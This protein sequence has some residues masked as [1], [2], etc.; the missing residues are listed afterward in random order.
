[1]GN[2]SLADHNRQAWDE[3]AESAE[4]W[5]Q[6]VDGSTL[7]QARQ[8]NWQVN[9]TATRPVPRAWLEPVAGARILCLAAGGGHQGPILAAAGGKVTVVD[10]SESQLAID[11]RLA[12]Q[13]SLP[14]ATVAADMRDLCQFESGQFDLV[15]NPCSLNFC[16][17]V[18][19]VWN[20]V[21]RVLRPGGT[22]VVGFL[23]PVNYLFDPVKLEHQQFHNL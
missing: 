3:I 7:E 5:F 18:Q 9:V 15:I 10:F 19:P 8:G 14:L 21:A 23:N 20:E 1:M 17:D 6:P 12:E 22:L 11:Q 13:H 2:D 16:P 4:Q